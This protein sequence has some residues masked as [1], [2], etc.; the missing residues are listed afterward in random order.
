MLLSD[1]FDY[2]LVAKEAIRQLLTHNG[3]PLSDQ[4]IA[5]HLRTEGLML[6]RRT[7]AKYRQQ[8]NLPSGY[9]RQHERAW[10]LTQEV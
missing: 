5:D 10:S 8:L 7:V 2:S 4:A 9:H 1:F 6:A 3:K